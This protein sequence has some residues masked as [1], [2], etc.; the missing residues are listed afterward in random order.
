MKKLGILVFI[1][2]IP[3]IASGQDKLNKLTAPTSPA[4]AILG[5]QPSAV[6]SP[7][8]YQSLETA[9]YSNFLNSE[10]KAVIPNDFALEF[11]PYWTKNHGLSLEQY[12]YPKSILHQVV[13]NTSFS[14]ASTQ[15]FLLGDSTATNGFAYGYRTTLYFGNKNDRKKINEYKAGLKTNEKIQ[16]KIV[17]EA[18]KLI[19]RSDIKNNIDFL[20]NI[21]SVVINAIFEHA[22]FDN[23]EDAR[24]LTSE[25][26][27]E[28][29][30]LPALDKNNPDTFLDAF[31]SIIDT[32][33]NAEMVFNN[34]E[35]YILERQGFFLNF[36]YAGLINFPTNNFEY[37]ILPHQAFWLTPA[38]RFKDKWNFFKIMGV[39]R[40]TWYDIKYYKKYFPETSVHN[41]NFDYGLAITNEFKKF[42]FQ[43]EAVGR[44]SDSEIPEGNDNEGN[45]IF[46]DKQKTDFQ[47]IGSFSYNINEQIIITYSLGNRFEPVKNPENTLISLFTLNFGFG[48]PTRED[49]DLE[50]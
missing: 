1:S 20:E 25:I 3:A 7:K 42:S 35:S 9:L 15:E 16:I 12:L 44:I 14:I 18:E 23:I 29:K 39:I 19:D 8:S 27:K 10:R 30:N 40:Y 48:S 33:L 13:R 34:F 6:I 17:S 47:Y 31:Y 50:K 5:L 36:A 37:S 2:L 38:Y 26:Y 43:I 4:S 32:K 49:L 22:G 41:N 46:K 45:T 28:A 11:T 21:K 24:A